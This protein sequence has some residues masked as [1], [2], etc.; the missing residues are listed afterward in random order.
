M[1]DRQN[2]PIEITTVE[3]SCKQPP[4]WVTTTLFPITILE[5]FI[6]IALHVEAAPNMS[7]K[8]VTLKTPR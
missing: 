5:F 8:L 1:S 7:S 2:F 3:T 6:A 4:S